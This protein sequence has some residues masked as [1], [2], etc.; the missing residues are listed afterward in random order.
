MKYVSIGD[1]NMDKSMTQHL[2]QTELV[3]C[4]HAT[5]HM[6][7]IQTKRTHLTIA[8]ILPCIG[9]KTRRVTMEKLASL[10]EL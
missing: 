7:N 6:C 2:R 9:T 3:A 10:V 8:F 5:Q 4:P 1:K